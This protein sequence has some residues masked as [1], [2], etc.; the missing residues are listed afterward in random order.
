MRTIPFR[1]DPDVR[2]V[3]DDTHRVAV[4]V[5]AELAAAT[6]QRQ[7][8]RSRPRAKPSRH[9]QHTPAAVNVHHGG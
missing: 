8:I 5:I 2:R 3:P 7:T 1:K 4:V 6:R 9:G